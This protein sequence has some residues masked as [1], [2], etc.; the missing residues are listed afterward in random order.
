[1]RYFWG[2]IS[3]AG[4]IRVSRLRELMDFRVTSRE[5]TD[6]GLKVLGGMQSL[7][8]IS[9]SSAAVTDAGVRELSRPQRLKQLYLGGISDLSTECLDNLRRERPGLSV[10]YEPFGPPP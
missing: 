5:I 4:L 6:E 2:S 1:V 3:D 9:L 8:K 10:V 7:E